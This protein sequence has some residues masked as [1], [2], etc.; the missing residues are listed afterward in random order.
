MWRRA[1]VLVA[2]LALLG[3]KGESEAGRVPLGGAKQQAPG[4]GP[5]LAAPIQAQLDSGNQAF[6]ARQLAAAE[7][8]YRAAA[9][10]DPGLAAPWMGVAMVASLK[11]DSTA[12][13]LAMAEVSKR[14]PSAARSHPVG[15]GGL[16]PGH[17]APE[18]AGTL[19]SGH[20]SGI[21]PASTPNR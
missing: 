18:T 8:H 10:L 12:A 13:R 9:K 2:V 16:P 19:P 5:A 17:P 6:R 4:G 15:G 14:A 7:E 1:T 11:G 3:C 21:P 20:P